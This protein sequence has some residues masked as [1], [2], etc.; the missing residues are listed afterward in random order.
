MARLAMSHWLAEVVRG[1]RCTVL[2]GRRSHNT[3]RSAQLLQL[4]R[5]VV[6]RHGIGDAGRTLDLA[7]D[8]PTTLHSPFLG[9][10]AA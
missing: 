1:E 8:K 10:T 7:H 6:L 5:C 3:M 4:C 9:A 2:D